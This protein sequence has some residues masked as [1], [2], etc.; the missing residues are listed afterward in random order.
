[1]ADIWLNVDSAVVVPLNIL[2]FTDDADFKSIETV[3][4]SSSL[5]LCWNFIPVTGSPT[6][7]SFVPASIDNRGNGIFTYNIPASSGTINNDSEG[8]GYFTGSGVGLLPFRSPMFG[9]R[10]SDIND[11]ELGLVDGNYNIKDVHKINLAVLSGSSTGGSTGTIKFKDPSGVTDRVTATVDEN[12]NRTA[13]T[14]NPD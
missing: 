4:S 9:F 1:M 3:V 2:P 12:G 7:V 14:L 11:V 8:F 6:Q 13:V 5:W 10:D